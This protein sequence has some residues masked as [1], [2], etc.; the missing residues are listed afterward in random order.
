MAQCAVLVTTCIFVHAE[1]ARWS[2]KKNAVFLV[3]YDTNTP[4]RPINQFALFMVEIPCTFIDIAKNFGRITFCR[5]SC[6]FKCYL[7]ENFQ[8][9]GI[10]INLQIEN[11]LSVHCSKPVVCLIFSWPPRHGRDRHILV[12][13]VGMIIDQGFL[14]NNSTCVY[15]MK[16]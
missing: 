9:N 7:L 14:T 10:K 2:Q 12:C 6:S 4:T 13:F 15:W 8:S 3:K 16:T 11:S 1:V 5:T